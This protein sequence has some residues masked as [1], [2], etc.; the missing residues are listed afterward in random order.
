MLTNSF[1]VTAKRVFEDFAGL[2]SEE[3]T[4]LSLAAVELLN[5]HTH[6][7]DCLGDSSQRKELFG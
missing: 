1:Y 3:K 4:W 2:A 5:S 7:P 6:L